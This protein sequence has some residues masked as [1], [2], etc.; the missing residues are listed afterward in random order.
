MGS[1]TTALAALS[2]N[3]RYIGIEI[4]TEYVKLTSDRINVYKEQGTKI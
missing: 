2:L 4:L 3:R 1:G